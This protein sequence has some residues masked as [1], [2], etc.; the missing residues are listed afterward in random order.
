MI[1]ALRA[2]ALAA[3]SKEFPAL[4]L[5]E[6]TCD[7]MDSQKREISIRNSYIGDF[8]QDIYSKFIGIEEWGPLEQIFADA[9]VKLVHI[10]SGN[11]R[12]FARDVLVNAGLVKPV[13]RKYR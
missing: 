5:V 1:P 11:T 3:A 2:L 10:D 4:Q 7:E 12:C 13:E 9:G 6:V 8:L